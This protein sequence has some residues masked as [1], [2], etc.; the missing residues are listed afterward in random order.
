MDLNRSGLRSETAVPATAPTDASVEPQLPAGTSVL[1]LQSTLSIKDGQ[2][3]VAQGFEALSEKETTQTVVLVTARIQADAGQQQ[4][5][6]AETRNQ[7]RIFRLQHA[8]ASSMAKVI[9]LTMKQ[10]TVAVDERTN[11]LI[12]SGS[13]ERFDEVEALISALDNQ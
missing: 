5:A 2:T 6:R 10:V 8:N 9:A 12:V 3:V 1:V 4:Q 11:A 13:S 7:L